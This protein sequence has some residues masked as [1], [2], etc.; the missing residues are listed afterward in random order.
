[1]TGRTWHRY[2]QGFEGQSCEWRVS[3][4]RTDLLQFRFS[5]LHTERIKEVSLLSETLLCLQREGSE[6][7]YLKGCMAQN[8]QYPTMNKL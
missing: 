5:S 2:R 8:G 3:P 4:R 1:M 7:I 6:S